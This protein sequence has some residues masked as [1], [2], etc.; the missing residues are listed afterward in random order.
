MA[1]QTLRRLSSLTSTSQPQSHRPSI[2]KIATTGT[3]IYPSSMTPLE[4][5]RNSSLEFT[6]DEIRKVGKDVKMTPLGS[7]VL[8]GAVSP[9]IGVRRSPVIGSKSPIISSRSTII[10]PEG[11]PTMSN[12]LAP[13]PERMLDRNESAIFHSIGCMRDVD[14]ILARV[15]DIDVYKYVLEDIYVCLHIDIHIYVYIH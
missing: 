9:V 4:M 13:L 6:Q 2:I 3:S 1:L 12:R 14:A 15:I 8:V 11:T 7:P 5:R 10:S